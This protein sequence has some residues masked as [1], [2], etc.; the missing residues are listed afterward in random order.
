MGAPRFYIGMALMALYTFGLVFALLGALAYGTYFLET[1]NFTEAVA[2]GT[3][4]VFSY[5]A[6]KNYLPTM[7]DMIW[8]TPVQVFK[9]RRVF[10]PGNYDFK[11]LIGTEKGYDKSYVVLCRPAGSKGFTFMKEAFPVN[12]YGSLWLEDELI[13]LAAYNEEAA[14]T[15]ISEIERSGREA[16][17]DLSYWDHRLDT[18]NEVAELIKS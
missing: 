14:K 10:A 16:K 11:M 5:Y 3:L 1:A 8:V 12:R 7:V 18:V 2:F 9:V 13:N 4:V 17:K 6:F 15:V